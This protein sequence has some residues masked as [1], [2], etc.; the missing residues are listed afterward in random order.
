[1][2][3]AGENTKEQKSC[4]KSNNLEKVEP[5]AEETSKAEDTKEDT[6]K[7]EDAKC[8]TLDVDT[9]QS[10]ATAAPVTSNTAEKTS[11]EAT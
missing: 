5:K 11:V 7:L 4:D 2:E 1:M 10:E 9:R 6:T 3:G 8:K